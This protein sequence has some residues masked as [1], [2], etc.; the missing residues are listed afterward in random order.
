MKEKSHP[1][2][3]DV[4][5][6]DSSTGEKFV[7]GSTLKPKEKEM[8]EGQEYPVFKL[9]VSSAS[10]PFFTGSKQIVDAEGRLDKF[11][12]RYERKNAENAAAV[13]KVDEQPEK[14]K[15]KK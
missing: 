6:V 5:F 15:K 10:H 4:L 8:F 13:A 3:Q 2:Y 12:K 1:D 9:A 14:K 7:A 11:K